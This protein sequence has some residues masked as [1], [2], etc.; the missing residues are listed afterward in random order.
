MSTG[1]LSTT[2]IDRLELTNFR[3][4][5]RCSIDFDPRLTVLIAPNGGGK[6]SVLDAA[7]VALRLFADTMLGL[8]ASKG[9][10]RNDVRMERQG[11]TMARTPP[12]T[13]AAA[14]MVTG[15][16]AVWNRSLASAAPHARTTFA[17]ATI[18]QECAEASRKSALG[19]TLPIL[20]YY[21]TGRL[22]NQGKL[23]S[24]KRT[25]YSGVEDRLGAYQDAL[26]PESNYKHL[27]D[28]L[29][30]YSY[31]AFRF[32]QENPGVSNH[33]SA[34]VMAVQY[35]VNYILGPFGWKNFR[36]DH[37]WREVVMDN[38]RGETFPGSILSDGV[39]N[40]MG[41]VADLAHRASRLNPHGWTQSATITPGIVL[42]D[43]VDMHLHPAWQ[44]TV[45]ASLQ[46]AFPLV[47]F[48]VTTHSPHILT[49]VRND[50][51]RVLSAD[52]TVTIPDVQTQGW[53]SGDVLARVMGAHERPQNGPARLVSEYF[54]QVA[55]G[56][57]GMPEGEA[58]LA[59]IRDHYGATHPLV[60]ECEAAARFA[61]FRRRN[62]PKGAPTSSQGS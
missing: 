21:G 13:V 17:N 4:F 52:G 27:V 30:R 56:T 60:L 32:N 47:Q 34:R 48:I 45:I 54:A 10:A 37:V 53:D 9:F 57:D 1:P 18:L 35:A 5:P 44:Q 36:F 25:R 55:E 42:V 31:E 16:Y 12:T 19:T 8:S 24:G 11:G 2:R 15:R 40:M 3:S 22:W 39:R 33:L 28:W 20:A 41:M 38:D 59:K 23:T 62:P 43:E 50:Q 61:A 49:T 58:L 7:V 46:A 26:T 51:I 14:G 29:W 6:T